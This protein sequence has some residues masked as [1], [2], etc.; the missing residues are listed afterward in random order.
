MV[1]VSHEMSFARQVASRIVFME[2]G[3]IVEEGAPEQMFDAPRF[4]RTRE[5]LNKIS[6]FEGEP[7]AR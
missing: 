7:A 3:F 1:V 4:E 5:F 2:G 6:S